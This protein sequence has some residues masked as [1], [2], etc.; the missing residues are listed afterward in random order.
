MRLQGGRIY[1]TPGGEGSKALMGNPAVPSSTSRSA[2]A[3]PA[4]AALAPC[5]SFPLKQL[6]PCPPASL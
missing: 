4:V 5:P 2:A 3:F 6:E 1:A